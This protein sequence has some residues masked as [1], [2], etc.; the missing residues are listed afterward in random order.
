MAFDGPA[1][2]PRIRAAARRRRSLLTF[3]FIGMPAP[4]PPASRP[5]NRWYVVTGGPSSGKTTLVTLLAARGYAVVHEH[6][7]QRIDLELR[8][9]ETLEDIRRDQLGFQRSVLEM[10]LEHESN[11]PPGQLTF[12]DRGIPDTLA[13]HRFH[14]LPESAFFERAVAACAYR[15]VFLLE[16][17]PLVNDYARKED[18]AAQHELQELLIAVYSALPFPMVRVPVMGPEERLDFVLARL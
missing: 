14:R 1:P 6:A 11:T 3:G 16:L 2:G 10:Q 17:L 12:F 18:V 9:G 7:R 13:Y 15:K 8:Y 4:A 5:A